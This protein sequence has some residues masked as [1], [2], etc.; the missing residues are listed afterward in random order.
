MAVLAVRLE[1]LAALGERHGQEVQERLMELALQR[2]KGRLRGT[3]T[4]ARIGDDAFGVA[5]FH[6]NSPVIGAIEARLFDELSAPYRVGEVSVEV[7]AMTGAAVFPRAGLTASELVQGAQQAL[8]G[9][10]V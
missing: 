9:K 2:L 7:M 5:L 3:D 6:V 1:G 4:V 10:G 8:E